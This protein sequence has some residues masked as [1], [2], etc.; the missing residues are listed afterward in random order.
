MSRQTTPTGARRTPERATWRVSHHL[1]HRRD[2]RACAHHPH[3]TPI[4]YLPITPIG[5]EHS[6][7]AIPPA[8]PLNPHLPEEN[9]VITS[10]YQNVRQESVEYGI[11]SRGTCAAQPAPSAR[12]VRATGQRHKPAYG[13]RSNCGLRS[14][15][16]ISRELLIMATREVWK[17]ALASALPIYVA[18]S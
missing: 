4:R 17:T 2:T 13:P 6:V 3:R 8:V 11:D 15:P 7:G 10:G 16:R 12:V 5:I 9:Q 1:P 18:V 14:I